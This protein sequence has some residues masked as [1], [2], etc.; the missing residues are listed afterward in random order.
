MHRGEA[1]VERLRSIRSSRLQAK[2]SQDIEEFMRDLRLPFLAPSALNDNLSS[3]RYENS[4]L[5]N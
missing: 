3:E 2:A 4:V 1:M 5:V